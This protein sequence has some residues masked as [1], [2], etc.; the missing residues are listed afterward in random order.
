MS[1]RDPL[2]SLVACLVGLAL[3]AVAAAG[4]TCHGRFPNPVT[5]ICWRCIFP[6]TIGN[7]PIVTDGQ[8]DTDNPSSP[9]CFCPDP[10]RVGVTIGCWPIRRPR[11]GISSAG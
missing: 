1:F 10:P 6:L 8:I 11:H 7:I 5:D 4:P 3:S 9:V 2:R